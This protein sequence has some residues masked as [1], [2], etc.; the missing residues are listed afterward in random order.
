MV[1]ARNLSKNGFQAVGLENDPDIH[2][3][4][5]Q[6]Q[7][8]TQSPRC[9]NIELSSSIAPPASRLTLREAGALTVIEKCTGSMSG[10]LSRAR[11]GAWGGQ[12]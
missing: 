3:R 2:D 5:M 1:G 12:A 10:Y 6:F 11:A 8:T 9:L 7:H 4:F